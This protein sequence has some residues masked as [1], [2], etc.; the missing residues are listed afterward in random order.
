MLYAIVLV[1]ILIIDQ[2]AK[3]WTSVKLALG[4]TSP[5]IPG[6]IKL[7]N[8]HNTGAAFGFLQNVEAARW[9]FVVLTLIIAVGAVIL[10]RRNI[11]KGKLGRWMLV[12][13]IAGGLGNCIDRVINGYVV[14][15]FQFQFMNFAIFNVSD[16]FITIC[17]VIFCFYLVFHKEPEEEP[18]PVPARTP[19][20]TMPKSAERPVRADYI[21]QL[22]KPVVEG[23]RNIEA[24]LAAKTAEAQAALSPEGIVTDWNTPDFGFDEKTSDTKKPEAEVEPEAETPD[25]TAPSP[26]AERSITNFDE[27]FKEPAKPEKKDDSDFNIEDIIAEFKDK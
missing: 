13:V 22:K 27:L 19:S 4:A 24:E 14:D 6:F 9:I 26:R 11:I 5:F 2:A 1:I 15:M 16:I 10:L 7:T 20:R 3:Y 21:S 23:R 18:L 8:V 25:V 17:G 12:L